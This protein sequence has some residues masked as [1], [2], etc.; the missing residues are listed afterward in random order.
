[1]SHG[2]KKTSRTDFDHCLLLE[3][4]KVITLIVEL[5]S[6]AIAVKYLKFPIDVSSR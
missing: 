4:S 5:L 3:A 2:S 1:M 6:V